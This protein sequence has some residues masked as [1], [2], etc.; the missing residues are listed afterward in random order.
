MIHSVWVEDEEQQL[1]EPTPSFLRTI[2]AGQNPVKADWMRL[3][4]TKQVMS[5][6][7]GLMKWARETLIRIIDPAST[8]I[9]FS[10]VMGSR[11]TGN[12]VR[13]CL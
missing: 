4:P 9:I 5:N 8:R 7:Q 10:V 2:P 1:P 3:T 6:H 11:I 12:L 13:F